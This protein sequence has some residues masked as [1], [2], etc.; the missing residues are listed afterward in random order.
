MVEVYVKESARTATRE[1][2]DGLKNI[3]RNKS[4][5]V[6]EAV[7][8]KVTR[9]PEKTGTVVNPLDALEGQRLEARRSI[10]QMVTNGRLSATE[11]ER[12]IRQ[13]DAVY[14][15]RKKTA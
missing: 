5:E 4:A 12:L 6:T 8:S 3:V 11:A 15:L 10:L 9:S 14:E 1:T 7:R 2:W 13:T